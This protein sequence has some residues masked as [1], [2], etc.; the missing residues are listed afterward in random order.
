MITHEQQTCVNR[1][2]VVKEW[3]GSLASQLKDMT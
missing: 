2:G 1:V 3:A